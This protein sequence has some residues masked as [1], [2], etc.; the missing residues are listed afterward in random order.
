[1]GWIALWATVFLGSLSCY[2]Q[3]ERYFVDLFSQDIRKKT[4]E[5]NK[6]YKFRAASPFYRL[7][8]NGDGKEE[9]FVLEKKD[10]EDWFHLHNGEGKRIYSSQMAPEGLDSRVHKINVRMISPITKVLI[11][12]FY[13]GHFG[14][15]DFKSTERLYFLTIDNKDL[16][17]VKLSMG[18]TVWDEVT[19]KNHYHQRRYE[20]FLYD[21]NNDGVKEIAVKH[22]HI[23][24]VF[25][26]R[27]KGNWT[28]L[29]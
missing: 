8:L 14:H 6:V 18:P 23:T 19:K 17:T 9:A 21:Y 15:I 29:K 24:R 22:Q 13:E 12:S 10:G 27:D 1:M 11:L 16:A 20:P 26:Y 5:Q 2:A 7:D 3:D 25:M 4:E 28:E